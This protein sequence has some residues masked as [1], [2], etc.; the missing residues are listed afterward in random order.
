MRHKLKK[1]ENKNQMTRKSCPN[2]SS[3]MNR[4]K[5][6][7]T[8]GNCDVEDLCTNCVETFPTNGLFLYP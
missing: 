3:P 1:V 2:C 4:Y 8:G 5:V 7:H 6:L